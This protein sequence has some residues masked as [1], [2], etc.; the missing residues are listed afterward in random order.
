METRRTVLAALAAAG[1]GCLTDRGVPATTDGPP[2]GETP[3]GDWIQRASNSFDP[4]HDVSVA[5]DGERSRTVRVRVT[6]EAT[7][8][9][10][11]EEAVEVAPG[12]ERTVYNLARADPDGIETFVVCGELLPSTEVPTATAT[13]TDREESTRD[14]SNP[15]DC[16][17]VETNEC[18]GNAIVA[19][20]ADGDL[21]VIYS[22]C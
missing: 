8:E 20:D 13:T 21:T 16:Q 18:F 15:E 10:V 17:S 5:N 7:G 9:T 22:I 12:A 4:D 2:E 3:T 6:R 11:F 19:V 1:A 14:G